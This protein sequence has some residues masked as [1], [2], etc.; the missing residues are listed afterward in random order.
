MGIEAKE[1]AG[2]QGGGFEAT[3][4]G[5]SVRKLEEGDEGLKRVVLMEN[6]VMMPKEGRVTLVVSH[7][8]FSRLPSLYRTP[9]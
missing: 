1:V 7:F 2:G 5:V 4:K 6:G 9:A 8:F 3:E